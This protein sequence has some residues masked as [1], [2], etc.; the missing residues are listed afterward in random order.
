MVGCVRLAEAY[1]NG[2]KE[3][4][5]SLLVKAQEIE[6]RL[7]AVGQIVPADD[8]MAED[9]AERLKLLG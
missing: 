8:W 4:A 5:R 9:L 7:R 6:S 1:A 3:K 2:S